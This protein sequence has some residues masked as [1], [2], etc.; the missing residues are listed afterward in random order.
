[1]VKHTQTI[2]RLLQTNFLSL[3][4]HFVKLRL[5]G[6]KLQWSSNFIINEHWWLVFTPFFC[7]WNSFCSTDFTMTTSFNPVMSSIGLP[8][9]KFGTFT[10]NV[11]D[12][13]ISFTPHPTFR[14]SCHQHK[15]RKHLSR[16]QVLVTF[17]LVKCWLIL[18]LST[19]NTNST[20][21][22]R[23]PKNGIN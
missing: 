8:L 18:H 20:F 10:H 5:K 2:R 19:V 13:L 17:S 7:H 23:K 4:D 16:Q 22:F 14:L 21:Q 1:M 3:F 9:G 12:C 6:L 11:V 15:S